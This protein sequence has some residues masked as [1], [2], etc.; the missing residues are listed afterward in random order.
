[1]EQKLNLLFYEEFGV[2][3]AKLLESMNISI[4]YWSNTGL[5]FS[6]TINDKHVLN[7]GTP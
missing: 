2:I 7:A 6:F 4:Y 5:A 3:S 1:M